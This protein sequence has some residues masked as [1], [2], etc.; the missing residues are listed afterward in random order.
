MPEDRLFSPRLLQSDKVERLTD[1][2]RGVWFV[3]RLV[4]DDFGVM[5]ASANA[6]Q[7]AARFLEHKPAATIKRALVALEKVGLL[8]GFEHEGRSYLYQ[9]DWQDWQKVTYPR[10]TRHPKPTAEQLE[11]CS[12][13]TRELFTKHP[14]GWGRKK[15]EPIP[16]G[17]QT[18]SETVPEQFQ[19]CSETVFPKPLAVSRKP[20]AVSTEPLAGGAPTAA[21]A[22]SKHPVFK[23]QRFV[24]F[25]WQL[26][27][28]SRMLGSH[29]DAFDL[30]A[31]F[32][33]L[34]AKA[35]S[36]GFVVPQRDGG[37]WLQEQ[38]QAE[39]IRRGIPIAASGPVNAKTAGNMAAAAR[40]IAR[41]G[42]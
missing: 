19:E 33:D 36:D 13:S 23:G 11:T 27:D 14:G 42:Q 39:A 17:S 30:H 7:D 35:V 20:L 31:W 1:F 5:R 24:V 2:E 21:N 34:D 18:V 16:N 41:G 29:T 40:F 15:S 28:L 10:G 4:C 3:S 6:L 32:F 25:D 22:R 9:W 37:K 8:Q 12:A 26:E 38:T